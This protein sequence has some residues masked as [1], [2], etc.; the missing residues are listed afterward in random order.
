MTW[1][2]EPADLEWLPGAWQRLTPRQRS[3]I[4]LRY[5]EDLDFATIAETLRC[6]QATARSHVSRGLASLREA[7]PTHEGTQ[8]HA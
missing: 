5:L 8:K 3:A 2:P 7:A 1:D 6:S 4:A